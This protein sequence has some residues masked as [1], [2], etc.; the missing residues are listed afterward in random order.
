MCIRDR[1]R[2]VICIKGK[3]ATSGLHFYRPGHCSDAARCWESRRRLYRVPVS[4]MSFV[5]AGNSART[6]VAMRVQ[7]DAVAQRFVLHDVH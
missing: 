1:C 2:A 4:I 5:C 6:H 7:C 3:V